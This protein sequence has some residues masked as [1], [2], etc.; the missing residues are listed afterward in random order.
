M[1]C[2]LNLLSKF[3]KSF[4]LKFNEVHTSQPELLIYPIPRMYKILT[5]PHQ[6]RQYLYRLIHRYASSQPKPK[7]VNIYLS[8]F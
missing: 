2:E 4:N 5:N 1:R 7:N 6:P 8:C 3:K